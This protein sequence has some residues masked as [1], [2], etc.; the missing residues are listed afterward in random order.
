MSCSAT[1]GANLFRLKRDDKLMILML[2][3]IARFA[4]EHGAGQ[5]PPGPDYFWGEPE[6]AKLL[7]GLTRASHDDVELIARIPD[8]EVQRGRDGPFFF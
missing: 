4:D 7:A 3:F 1:A 2:R 6:Y 8:N 5:P